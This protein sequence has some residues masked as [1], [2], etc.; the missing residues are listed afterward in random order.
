MSKPVPVLVEQDGLLINIVIIIIE[1]DV[2]TLIFSLEC[3]AVKK[4]VDNKIMQSSYTQHF[5]V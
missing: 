5:Q 4:G 3:K 1:G 2:E